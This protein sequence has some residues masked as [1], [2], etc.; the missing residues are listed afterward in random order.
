[1]QNQR[2]TPKGQAFWND[3]IARFQT[4]GLG[5]LA[6]CRREGLARSSFGSHLRKESAQS[7]PATNNGFLEITAPRQNIPRTDVIQIQYGHAVAVFPQGYP[8]AELV[9]ILQALHTC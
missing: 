5:Q 1:M 3:H 2:F 4:S 9:K 6:Y 8:T 7:Q